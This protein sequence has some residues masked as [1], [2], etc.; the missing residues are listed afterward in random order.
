MFNRLISLRHPSLRLN[1]FRYISDYYEILGVPR[2]ASSKDIKKAYYSKAKKYHPDVAGDD[3][4]AAELFKDISE[5]YEVLN[6][7]KT[8]A[9]YDGSSVRHEKA[10]SSAPGPQ[11]EWEFRSNINPEDLF[12]TVFGEFSRNFGGRSESVF[13]DFSPFGFGTNASEISISIPFIE[14]VKGI[15]KDIEVVETSISYPQRIPKLIKR[16]LTVNIPPGIEDGQTLR[17]SIGG[18]K[19]IFVTVRVEE[20]SH[21]RRS[22]YDVHTDASISIG[23]ALLGGILRVKGLY[24]DLNVRIPSGTS[25]HSTLRLEGKGIKKL[26]TFGGYGTH[27]VHLKIDVPQYISQEQKDLIY[28]FAILDENTPE[29]SVTGLKDFKSKKKD[30]SSDLEETESL[31]F[32][33]KLKKKI[34]G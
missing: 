29:W 13:E 6:D 33:A 9:N 14:A 30:S 5:A 15:S 25:S 31:G 22:Q 24:S 3:P 19:E 10:S 2:N 8:R 28:R 11:Y 7:S 26:D 17:M 27:F 32:F 4:K 21:F 12:R 23:Q 16:T 18:N 1:F 34:L 20:S